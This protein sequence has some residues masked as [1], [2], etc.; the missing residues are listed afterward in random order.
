[1]PRH[2]CPVCKGTGKAWTRVQPT[3]RSKPCFED[4]RPCPLCT[5]DS[6]DT[7]LV[8]LLRILVGCPTI[9]DE[10]RQQTRDQIARLTPTVNPQ[11]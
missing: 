1:M 4:W 7:Q 10:I 5:S 9:T 11:P 2:D 6:Q 3:D 8:S